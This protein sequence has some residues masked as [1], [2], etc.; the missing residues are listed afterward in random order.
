MKYATHKWNVKVVINGKSG[1]PEY[2]GYK[3]KA[4]AEEIAK[5]WRDAGYE[6]E[7]IKC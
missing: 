2:Y 5:K 7:V 1:I 3:T 4:Q 6:A